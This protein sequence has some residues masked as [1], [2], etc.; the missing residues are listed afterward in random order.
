MDN[1][2]IYLSPPH[3]NGTE[4]DYVKETFESNWIAPLGP[5]VDAFERDVADYVGVRHSTSLSSGTAGIH[6]ALKY[7]DVK[8][9]DYVFCSAFT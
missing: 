1:K 6:L 5:N 4:I 8:Q 9:D 7:L 3:M 2:R